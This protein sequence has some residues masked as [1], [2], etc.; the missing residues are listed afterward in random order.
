MKNLAYTFLAS[1]I[2]AFFL[3]SCNRTTTQT[4]NV[5]VPE[6]T[7]KVVVKEVLQ[8]TV[9]TYLF[10]KEDDKEYWMATNKMEAKSGDTYYY[11]SA[12]EMPNFESKELKRTFESLLLVD[13]IRTTPQATST[14]PPHGMGMKSSGNK[15]PKDFEVAE[16]KH[17][18]GEIS[19]GELYKNPS[20]FSGKSIKVRGSVVKFNGDIMN[21]NWIHIQDGSSSNGKF[22]LTITSLEK[23][24]VGEIAAFEGIIV[25][26]KDFGAGYKY[27]VI[28]EDAKLLSS[29]T[30]Q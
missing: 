2:F 23:V 15:P 27:D 12:Y 5:E 10:V 16:I 28:M 26:D 1:F 30:N 19:I 11:E 9:Y 29:V 3:A 14:M 20:A 4:H 8:T 24:N 21:K 13:N 6:G 18:A 22:D 17:E 25:L 7:H